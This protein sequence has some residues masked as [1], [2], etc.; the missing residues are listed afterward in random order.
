MIIFLKQG[1]RDEI[2]AKL[3]PPLYEKRC[4]CNC[5]QEVVHFWTT[6][7]ITRPCEKGC[8]IPQPGNS[9]FL[10]P[11]SMSFGHKQKD[12]EG[13]MLDLISGLTTFAAFC[14]NSKTKKFNFEPGKII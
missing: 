2:K 12:E 14:L 6:V 10:V 4:V 9:S 7:Q 11:S 1:K 3:P 5:Q 13:E 8:K